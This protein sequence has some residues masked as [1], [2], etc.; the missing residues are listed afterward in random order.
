MTSPRSI[1]EN[2]GRLA[3][4]DFEGGA[5]NRP[6]MISAIG[7]AELCE[8]DGVIDPRVAFGIAQLPADHSDQSSVE[9]R[10]RPAGGAGIV[11]HGVDDID[12]SFVGGA[13]RAPAGREPGAGRDHAV[14]D[15]DR[16]IS[17]GHLE[18]VAERQDARSGR[19]VGN[20]PQI[21]EGKLEV[22]AFDLE[23]GQV[24]AGIPLEELRRKAAAVVEHDADVAAVEQMAPDR[25]DVPVGRDEQTGAVTLEIVNAA[26]A[27]NLD[28][29]RQRRVQSV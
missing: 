3:S 6:A 11:R 10:Q 12:R 7:P 5:V 14:D 9:S 21:E 22:V 1:A 20:V 8:R 28:H 17:G 26:G 25:H 24:A 13:I 23:H 2:R 18:H 16:L 29:F 27:E 15:G 4:S 19:G